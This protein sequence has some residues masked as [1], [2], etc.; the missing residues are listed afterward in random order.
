MVGVTDLKLKD[1]RSE[2]WRF[3]RGLSAGYFMGTLFVSILLAG[4]AL[5]LRDVADLDVLRN[6]LLAS[7][8]ILGVTDLL[9]RTPNT[10]RQVPQR[11]IRDVRPMPRGLLWGFDLSLLVTTQKTASLLWVAL[12]GLILVGPVEGILP[13]LFAAGTV[14]LGGVVVLS[15]GGAS[16]ITGLD[17]GR[18]L[19]PALQRGSGVLLIGLAVVGWAS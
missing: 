11:F 15:F 4:L 1:R 13:A 5:L 9:G 2:G 19:I 7:S 16:K 18:V 10:N 3:L 8:L 17:F 12:L 14:Y 6:L